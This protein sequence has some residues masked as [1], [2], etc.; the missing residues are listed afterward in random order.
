M[1]FKDIASAVLG[2]L[3]I[4]LLGFGLFTFFLLGVGIAIAVPATIV[5]GFWNWVIVPTFAFKAITFLQ[6]MLSVL[7]SMLL[8]GLFRARSVA[9]KE[10]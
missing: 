6:A 8:S 4:T 1:K 10:T 2:F 3:G 7:F 5:Y 9:K